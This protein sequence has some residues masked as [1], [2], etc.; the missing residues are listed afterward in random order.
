MSNGYFSSFAQ[1]VRNTVGRADAVN[2]IFNLIISA[3]DKLPDE[4]DLKQGLVPL[5]TDTGAADAYVVAMTYQPAAYTTGLQVVFRALDTNT[6]PSTINV[7]GLGVKAIKRFDGGAM[8]PGEIVAGGMVELRYDGTAFRMTNGPPVLTL[9]YTPVNKA[10]DTGIGSLTS[11][12]TITAANFSGPMGGFTGQLSPAQG[13]TG[14]NSLAAAL[15]A[16]LPSQAGQSGKV[17][18]TNGTVPSWQ[19]IG[20]VSSIT[21]GT[22][23]SGGTIT[24]SGTVA[25]ANTAVTAG[26]YGS[27][28]QVATFT[29][30]A[31]GRLTAAGNTA[32]A[33]T[34][35]QVS[36]NIA[37]SAANVTGTVALANGGTG[38]T[39]APAALNVLLPTQAGQSGKYLTTDGTNAAWGNPAG[40]GTVTSVGAGTGLT[41]GPITGSGTLSL[42]NTAV[43][44]GSYGGSAN[45]P[46]FTVDA[47]GRLTAAGTVAVA[48]NFGNV[49]GTLGINQGGTGQ[50]TAGAAFNA[51]APAQTG[52][53]GKFLTTDGT[54]VSWGSPPSNPGTVTSIAFGT[55]LTGGTITGSGSV[56]LA[57]TAVTIGSYGSA[58]QVAT[59]TV[60][61]QGRLT[62]AGNATI[63]I[64]G[65]N[66]SGN[67]AGN[68]GN[69]TGIVSLA[70]GGLG[71]NHANVAAVRSTLGIGSMALRN[72]TIST[73][74]PSGGADGDIWLQY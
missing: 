23:L 19:A 10:G 48:I 35:A 31:Q 52:Q 36:G 40:S 53:N 30:D 12:G 17:L 41:G 27:A 49:S 29:V 65:S 61:Q 2:A 58:T 32:I 9:G 6:G 59:F 18:S 11:T 50:T 8:G 47:Q 15:A 55:G 34:G 22:G 72:V 38:Q 25:L 16:M 66:V 39:T 63:S 45:I 14:Q 37:G 57:N 42:A 7:G 74:T 33:I 1:L 43:V 5:G 68:A 62:A 67:I 60:D 44:A 56:N 13:G 21:A 4:A 46:T 20:S 54:N 51:L 73:S 64:N 28:S 3:F 69:V 26:G 70:N 24:T 71:A